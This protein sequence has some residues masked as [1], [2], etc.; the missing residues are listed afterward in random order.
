MR[1]GPLDTLVPQAL[2]NND[3]TSAAK[4]RRRATRPPL[5]FFPGRPNRMIDKSAHFFALAPNEVNISADRVRLA[6]VLDRIF[7]RLLSETA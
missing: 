4:E 5:M 3:P 7:M 1:L 2:S 6:V